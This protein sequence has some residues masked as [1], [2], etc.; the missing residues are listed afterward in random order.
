MS[1]RQ[2]HQEN[3]NADWPSRHKHFILL[4]SVGWDVRHLVVKVRHN[5]WSDILLNIKPVQKSSQ[6]QDRTC[7]LWGLWIFIILFVYVSCYVHDRCCCVMTGP[8]LPVKF[9][10]MMQLNWSGM[11]MHSGWRWQR[12]GGWTVSRLYLFSHLQSNEMTHWASSQA[13]LMNN[14]GYNRL[15]KTARFYHSVSGLGRRRPS[16][17]KDGGA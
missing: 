3:L 17:V 1:G 15:W 16:T 5:G 8:L 10:G 4:S 2:W 7:I 9:A 12:R 14:T 11:F 6:D 13:D